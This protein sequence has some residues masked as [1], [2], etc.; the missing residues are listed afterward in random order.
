MAPAFCKAEGSGKVVY[1]ML[2]QKDTGNDWKYRGQNVPHLFL[3]LSCTIPC[4]YA[5]ISH[6]YFSYVDKKSISERKNLSLQTAKLRYVV[7]FES[8]WRLYVSELEILFPSSLR[9]CILWSISCSVRT[10]DNSVIIVQSPPPRLLH[11]PVQGCS[12]EDQAANLV[13]GS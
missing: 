1:I 9:W 12:L 5:L 10:M 6:H 3:C 8:L 2:Y 4:F 7:C 11:S 13:L